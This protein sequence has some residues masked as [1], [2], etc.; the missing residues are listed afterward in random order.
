[1]DCLLC[2]KPADPNVPLLKCGCYVCPPCYCS[3]KSRRI[4]TCPVCSALLWRGHK[5][6]K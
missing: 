1:M 4:Y 3:L 6:N 5:K 2:E